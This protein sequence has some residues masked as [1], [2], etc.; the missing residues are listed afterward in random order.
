MSIFKGSGVALITPFKKSNANSYGSEIDYDTL[1]KLI[2]YHISNNTD[3][4][5]I[6]G[7]TGEASTLTY[8]EHI[9]CIK[10]C[11][12][13]VNKRIPVIAGVG[14]NDTKT[15]INLAVIA[16]Q[17]KSDGLLVVTPYYNK[18]NQDGLINAYYGKIA[19]EVNIPIILYNVP[20]RTGVNILPKTAHELHKKYNNIIGIKEAS[21][22]IN[23]I[24]ELASISDIDIYSGNDDQTLP[25]LSLGGIGVISVLANVCPKETH[26]M[27]YNYLDG[28]TKK[29]R[30][31]H[32]RM[33]K[34]C[35]ELFCDVNP[36][37]VKAL[38]KHLKMIPDDFLREPLISLNK[39]KT[40]ILINEY[41]KIKK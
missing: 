24:S 7:T 12:E 36:I 14:N 2:E 33:L 8:Y 27:V 10:R 20:S 37:P 26:N 40:K 15:A 29:S 19:N 22:D 17:L 11:I 23:Q 34:L 1:E 6:C 32:L 38:M 41:N 35:K 3:A 21:G 9:N 31:Q 39:D 28:N 4:I 25:I 18:T 5:I 16:A 30:I 13:I